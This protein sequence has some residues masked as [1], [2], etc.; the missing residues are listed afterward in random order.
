MKTKIRT[1][2]EKRDR[3]ERE[4]QINED[5]QRKSKEDI[6]RAKSLAPDKVKLQELANLLTSIAMPAVK[7]R[8]S[9]EIVM[10]VDTELQKIISYIE[11]ETKNI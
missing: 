10:H 3:E 1:D 8:K 11:A 2:K 7:D 6:E 9:R 4:L 5:A